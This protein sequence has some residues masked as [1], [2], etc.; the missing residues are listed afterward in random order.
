MRKFFLPL[1]A[2]LL[3]LAL[4]SCDKN[5]NVKLTAIDE[6]SIVENS[7]F[8][9][10]TTK[11]IYSTEDTVIEYVILN[12]KDSE[13]TYPCD[14]IYLHKLQDGIWYEVAFKDDMVCFEDLAGVLMP[15]QSVTV[16]L[17]LNDDFAL[18]LEAG[19][20]RIAMGQLNYS[21]TFSNIFTVQ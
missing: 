11:S 15:N 12:L 7:S 21:V 9:I 13:V 3:I 5:R 16:K 8:T 4:V 14:Y 6:N 10:T 18:P 19:Q 1:M 20:Y 2:I 17:D